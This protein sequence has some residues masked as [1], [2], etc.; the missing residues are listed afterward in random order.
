MIGAKKEPE[1]ISPASTLEKLITNIVGD[2]QKADKL[3]HGVT[4]EKQDISDQIRQIV[5]EELAA[6]NGRL[7][8][9]SKLSQDGKRTFP[10]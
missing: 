5:K 4:V 8:C 3:Y 9:S 10:V 6:H 7:I 1:V 2:T